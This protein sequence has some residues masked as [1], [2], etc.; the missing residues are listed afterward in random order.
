MIKDTCLHDWEL[1][2]LSIQCAKVDACRSCEL[3]K[4]MTSA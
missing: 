2:N 4:L 3:V 1:F